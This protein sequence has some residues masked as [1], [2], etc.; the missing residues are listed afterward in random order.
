MKRYSAL[1]LALACAGCVTPGEQ[2]STPASV[3]TT[4][5]GNYEWTCKD[6]AGALLK[7]SASQDAVFEVCT[8]AALAKPG[9][10]FDMQGAHYTIVG[11]NSVP[12]SPESDCS[13]SPQP[14]DETRTQTCPA[15]SSGTW[16]QTRAYSSAAYPACW[17]AGEWT[18]TSAPAGACTSVPTTTLPPVSWGDARFANVT[19]SGKLNLSSG[20]SKSNLSIEEQSGDPSI[21]CNGSC[22][23]S[24]I[25]IKSREGYRCVS[26]TQ[27]LSDMYVE[28]I[29]TGSDHADGLQCYNPGAS[30][31]VTV[32]N[33]TFKVGGAVNAAYFSADNWMGKHV[34][35]NV[36]IWGGG[37]GLRLPAD[38]GTSVKLKDVFF[39]KGS[40]TYGPF[41]FDVVNGK[42]ISID[43]W[44]NV[45]WVTISNGQIVMGDVIPRP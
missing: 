43:Q 4:R 20:A 27:N 13:E 25:R 21:I 12:P 23:L 19:S 6:P 15:G 26:G 33:T 39:V 14:A 31:T 32:K 2:A 28:S 41:M 17:S 38:G 40:F 9:A 42:Q 3:K 11:N 30:G 1:L 10:V 22:T 16:T 45:R 29:G 34:L 5:Q 44:E 37:F 7:G 18:P 8:N 36:L 35:E 24:T